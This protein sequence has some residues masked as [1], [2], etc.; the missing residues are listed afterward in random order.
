[1]IFFVTSLVVVLPCL[2]NGLSV[3]TDEAFI[4]KDEV[5]EST[6]DDCDPSTIPVM[7]DFDMNRF[8]GSWYELAKSTSGYIDVDDGM[9]KISNSNGSH[10]FLFSGRD[11]NRHCIKPIKGKIF[12]SEPPGL[13]ELHYQTYSTHVHETVRVLFTDYETIAVIYTCIHH[14]HHEKE[15]CHSAG[16][17]GAIWT[18]QPHVELEVYEKAQQFLEMACIHRSVLTVRNIVGPC[19]V[20]DLGFQIDDFPAPD[21]CYQPMDSGSCRGSVQRYFYD[22]KQKECKAFYYGGCG[23]NE[24]NFLSLSECQIKCSSSSTREPICASVAKCGLHCSPC[25]AEDRNG[26][27]QCNCEHIIEDNFWNCQ[28]TPAHCDSK[29][30]VE[31]IYEGCYVCRC[32]GESKIPDYPFPDYPSA[33]LEVKKEGNCNERLERYYYDVIAS[34][35]RTFIYTGC[36]G[37]HNNFQ[38]LRECQD[39]CQDNHAVTEQF[40]SFAFGDPS[41]SCMLKENIVLTTILL[42]ILCT[43]SKSKT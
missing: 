35:C 11:N 27:V 25:C 34:Q 5:L 18:R 30:I 28:K 40:P 37:N 7:N 2:A 14:V 15:V 8:S 41:S 36:Q 22:P 6:S 21:F 19:V 33:C 1:M 4:F 29:C 24:N 42:M 17:F 20:D 31:E 39:K 16:L 10:V 26:C 38:T 3:R 9:W 23:G 13:I 32:D 43:L 12:A